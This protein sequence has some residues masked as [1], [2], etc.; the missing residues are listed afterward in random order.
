M[1]KV[2]LSKTI[3]ARITEADYLNLK[4]MADNEQMT[5]SKFIN[6]TLNHAK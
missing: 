5:V 4:E 6:K 1:S 2:I 3:S